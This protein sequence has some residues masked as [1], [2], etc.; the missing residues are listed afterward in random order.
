MSKNVVGAQLYT[1]RE[2]T[3]TAADISATFRKVAEIG[4]TAIQ[5]S[6]FG[7]IDRQEVAQLAED[8]G[9][10]ISSTHTGWDRRT[11]RRWPSGST[12]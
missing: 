3:Q 11:R 8:N 12:G 2:F 1:V 4:Y 10:T 5:I 7:A 6:A 9:L